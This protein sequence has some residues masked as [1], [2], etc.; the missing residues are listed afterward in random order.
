MTRRRKTTERTL[1]RLLGVQ[2]TAQGLADA[3]SQHIGDRKLQELSATRVSTTIEGNPA[4]WIGL[5]GRDHV[6]D[7][8]PDASAITGLTL[9][10]N[11]RRAGGLLLIAVD[12]TMYAMTF[13]TGYPLPPDEITDQDFGRDFIIRRLD[14][15]EVFD[16]V[17]RRP[18]SRGRT[19]TVYIPAGAPVWTFGTAE[20]IDIIRRAGGLAKDLKVTFSGDDNRP[21]KIEGCVG[22]RMKF[23]VDPPDLIDDIRKCARVCREEEPHPALSF[24]YNIKRVADPVIRELLD[25]ELDDILGPGGDTSRLLPVVPTPV[26]DFYREARAFTYKIGPGN[27]PPRRE[28]NLSYILS[29]TRVMPAGARRTALKNGVLTLYSDDA[30]HQELAHA[31]ADKWLEASVPDCGRHYFLLDGEWHEIGE[32]YAESSRHEIAPLFKEIPGLKLPEWRPGETEGDYSLRVADTN[33]GVY[34]CL[35]KSRK[36][37]NP[38]GRRSPLEICDLL[39]PGNELI[40]AKFAERSEPLSHLFFQGLNALL[41]YIYG[42]AHVRERFVADVADHRRVLAADFMPQKVVFAILLNKGKKLTP[43][44]LF[45]FAQA[46]L[47]HAAR[48]LHTYRGIEVEAIG[49]ESAS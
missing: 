40:L 4:I 49:I 5:P 1:Y 22:L 19:E 13:G 2:P 18:E 12:G 36:V 17:R 31:R 3:V 21:V 46:S 34:L 39:G 42:P 45:P 23:G 44:T 20:S 7:W 9:A 8:C 27:P 25:G 43:D 38:L 37:R 41:S 10:Y 16:L 28:F 11:E 14:P 15:D 48:V 6:A 33:P 32:T 35:D 24:I 30:G 47:A 26:L 29:R